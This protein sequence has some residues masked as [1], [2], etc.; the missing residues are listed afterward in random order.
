MAAPTGRAASNLQERGGAGAEA[1]TLHS[2]IFKHDLAGKPGR[3]TGGS[4]T[5]APP[6]VP[7][8]AAWVVDEASMVQVSLANEVLA[9][10]GAEHMRSLLWV[11]DDRQLPAIGATGG[12]LL[13]DL[14]RLDRDLVPVVRLTRIFRQAPSGSGPSRIAVAARRVSEGLAPEGVAAEL[15]RT[16]RAPPAPID[17]PALPGEWAVELLDQINGRDE[18]LVTRAV[19]RVVALEAARGRPGS[20]VAANDTRPQV[21]AQRNATVEKLNARL[22]ELPMCNPRATN[23][24]PKV[25][26]PRRAPSGRDDGPTTWRV[27]DRVLNTHN[28][29]VNGRRVIA[30][31]DMGYIESITPKVPVGDTLVNCL[32]VGGGGVSVRQEFKLGE[33]N[34]HLLPG[35]ACTV[36]KAQGAEYDHCVVVTD[37]SLNFQTREALYTGVSR[38][39]RSTTLITSE[40]HVQSALANSEREKRVTLLSA[41]MRAE[42]G[43][44]A[45][46]AA[47]A[48]AKRRRLA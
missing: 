16:A 43:G 12:A 45:A 28:R 35:W 32:F 5:I 40:R 1:S 7:H 21:L 4:V 48:A 9:R 6:P 30:N 41:R 29:N 42:M 14:M 13:R 2:L 23:G 18:L 3:G 37:N 24:P 22:R 39:K 25:E 47:A 10:F 8:G 36:H 34:A 27:G 11:G 20:V 38:G 17:G 31:G 19:E 26:V 33:A 15:G 46:V 44:D